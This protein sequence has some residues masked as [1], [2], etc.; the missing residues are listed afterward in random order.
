MRVFVTGATGFVGQAA[1]R[2]LLERGHTVLGLTRDAKAAQTLLPD[3]SLVQGGLAEPETLLPAVARFG[4]EALLHLAWEGL[5]DYSEQTSRRNVALGLAAFGLAREAGVAHMVATGSC[6][7][8]ASRRGMLA[9]DAP[10]LNDQPFPAAKNRLHAEGRALANAQG[11]GFTWLRLFFVYGPGQ[12]PG[13]LLPSLIA[14]ALK[15]APP[16]LRCPANRN[17]FLHVNDV[18]LALALTLERRPPGA[19]YN[20]GSG[21]PS[22]VADVARIVYAHLGREHLLAGLDDPDAQALAEDFWADMTQ[23]AEAVGFVPGFGLR[24]GIAGMIRRAQA[25]TQG[26]GR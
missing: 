21:N 16:A 10:L 11:V 5:P 3:A 2:V 12:R 8:Y 13:S 1:V 22:R 26:E 24:E 14:A 18:A 17:D 25:R 4:P 6:W 15:G 19:A 9:E 20:V 7:E 23:F